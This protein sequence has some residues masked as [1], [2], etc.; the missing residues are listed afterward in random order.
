MRFHT[1]GLGVALGGFGLLGIATAAPHAEAPGTVTGKVELPP[2]PE[3]APMAQQGF[4]ARSENSMQNPQPPPLAPFMFVVLDGATAAAPP[5]VNWELVGESF[6]HPVVA[7]MAGADVVIKNSSKT[8]RALVSVEDPSLLSNEVLNPSGAKTIH[9]AAGKVY[10]VRDPEATYVW[11]R[12]V[13]VTTPYIGYLDANGKFD[14][15]DVPDGSY[16]IRVFYKDA[17]LDVEQTV[18]ITPKTKTENV[19]VRVTSLKPAAAK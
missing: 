19:T 2:A 17:W 13:A 1:I 15:P 11:G 14:I 8:S 5:Q 4:V 6:G 10:T 9:V 3:L 12:I 7:A 16:R 18:A